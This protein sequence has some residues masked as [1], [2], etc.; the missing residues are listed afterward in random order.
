MKYIIDFEDEPFANSNGT[1][2]YRIKGSTSVC[3]PSSYLNHFPKYEEPVTS[4]KMS[5][6][7][8]QRLKELENLK[9]GDVVIAVNDVGVIRRM[10][11][12]IFV[13]TGEENPY[14][15][16]TNY[17][18]ITRR[19]AKNL[20]SLGYEKSIIAFTTEEFFSKS[21]AAEEE[22]CDKTVE[23]LSGLQA[24]DVI[25]KNVGEGRL[26]R[27]MVNFVYA[28]PAASYEL[29]DEFGC[30][31]RYSLETIILDGWHKLKENLTTQEFYWKQR[32][33]AR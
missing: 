10:G 6:K 30:T 27:R 25:Y 17:G 20:F 3:V 29:V 23:E 26:L 21:K 24:G 22:I 1:R 14:E 19:N 18:A 11:L 4:P 33:G 9:E 7:D 8:A 2:L 5:E 32:G 15:I 31:N 28:R 12:V 16:V 13:Y